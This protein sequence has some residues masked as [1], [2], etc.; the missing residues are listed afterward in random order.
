[1]YKRASRNLQH[2]HRVNA[3][4]PTGGYIGAEALNDDLIPSAG[5]MSRAECEA[6]RKT[7]L[8]ELARAKAD[9]AAAKV[10]QDKEQAK[11]L[12]T[13]IGV[14]GAR[15]GVINARLHDLSQA[16]Q[17]QAF[18]QATREIVNAE[19]FRAIVAR[20]DQIVAIATLTEGAAA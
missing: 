18:A 7:L 5:N 10:V 1:M 8:F 20:K 19:T 9:L 11:L 15:L 17:H 13:R 16:S 6:E 12:G 2:A 3:P 4:L 14:F